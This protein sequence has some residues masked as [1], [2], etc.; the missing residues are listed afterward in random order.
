VNPYL[1]YTHLWSFSKSKFNLKSDRVNLVAQRLVL[2]SVCFIYPMSGRYKLG[3]KRLTCLGFSNLLWLPVFSLDF[4]LKYESKIFLM[5]KIKIR[6]IFSTVL[7][8]RSYI[9]KI[10]NVMILIKRNWVFATHSDYSMF[11]T[12]VVDLLI[13]TTNS[14]RWNILSLKHQVAKLK[15]LEKNPIPLL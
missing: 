6:K 11:A 9:I 12:H 7:N 10:K 15:G 1:I 2:L 5:S 13:R 8:K 4:S 3:L 14:V